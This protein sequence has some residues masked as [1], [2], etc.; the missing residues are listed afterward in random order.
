MTDADLPIVTLK[1]D[2]KLYRRG[3]KQPVKKATGWQWFANEK[4][5][6]S[7]DTYGPIISTWVLGKSLRL[8]DISTSDTRK[9]IAELLDIPVQTIDCDEQYSGGAGNR[10]VH[11]R[12]KP[13]LIRLKLQGTIIREDD[14]DSDCEGADEVVLFASQLSSLA[15]DKDALTL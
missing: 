2:S 9:L 15:I 5:Y 3:F 1:K 11:D 14:A 12:F 7:A 8:L 6:G 13:L 10:Q 4:G